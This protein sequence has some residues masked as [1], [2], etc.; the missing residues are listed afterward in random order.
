MKVMDVDEGIDLEATLETTNLLKNECEECQKHEK[1]LEMIEEKMK[2]SQRLLDKFNKCRIK[3]ETELDDIRSSYELKDDECEQIYHQIDAYL[4]CPQIASKLPPIA[5]IRIQDLGEQ[6]NSLESENTYIHGEC[7]KQRDMKEFEAERC[8]TIESEGKL[9]KARAED[10]ESAYKSLKKSFEQ[11][12]IELHEED[13]QKAEEIKDLENDVSRSIQL[14]TN[15]L[16]SPDFVNDEMK[17]EIQ[18]FLDSEFN[19]NE[20]L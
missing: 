16:N 7:I 5:Q 13:K 19:V 20:N 18:K 9:L 8:K 6:I 10:Q 3:Y 2:D 17:Q 4:N 12:L 14:F 15:I 11:K 1:R